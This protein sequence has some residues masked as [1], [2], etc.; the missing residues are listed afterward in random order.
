V[1]GLL[2]ACQDVGIS[3]EIQEGDVDLNELRLLPR[4]LANDNDFY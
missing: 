2:G 1:N 3:L 4:Y